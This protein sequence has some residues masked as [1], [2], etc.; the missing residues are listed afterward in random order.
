MDTADKSA[1][2]TALCLYHHYYIRRKPQPTL[3]CDLTFQL[4]THP[5]LFEASDQYR[6]NTMTDYYWTEIGKVF[7]D[8]YPEQSLELVEPM[9]SHFGVDGVIFDVYSQTCSVLD[10]IMKQYP[11]DVWERVSKLLENQTPSSRTVALEHWLREGSTLAREG[12]GALT[13]IPLEKIEKIWE[14][15]D[16]DVKERAWYFAYRLVPQT[17]SIEEWPT[18]LTRET[19]I[20]YGERKDVRGGLGSNC[21]TEMWNGPASLHYKNKQQ[22]LL[23]IKDE[24][25]NE[26]VKRWIDEFVAGLEKE[27]ERAKIDEEGMF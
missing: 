14:W 23:H 6:F 5:S 26:Y 12:K 9:L 13:L 11:V 24:E 4:L 1:M 3:S 2:S 25:D 17:L 7:R 20:R 22:K 21:S 16:E 27:I 10:E 8:C 19:L 15:I 18:S